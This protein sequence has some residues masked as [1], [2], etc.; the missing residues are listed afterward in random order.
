M[1]GGTLTQ[2]DSLICSGGNGFT[3]TTGTWIANDFNVALTGASANRFAINGGTIN[4][5]T[6]TWQTNYAASS[7]NWWVGSGTITNATNSTIKFVTTNNT[8]YSFLGGTKTYGN[9]WFARG[10]STATNTISSSNTFA[11]F[12]DDGSAAHS[13][14][15]T[16]G[17]TQTV[18]TFT[19]SGTAG[20]L[21][22]IDSTTTGT[23][24]LVKSGGGTISSDYLNIQHSVAT[25][26]D[27]WYAGVNSTDNQAATTA[28][29]GWIFTAPPPPPPSTG[30]EY[31]IL[32]N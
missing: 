19:V 12:K 26:S 21:I 15:F 23:H 5:G 14:L 25:P 32:F 1:V 18:T 8:D 4:M 3:L 27:T 7:G 29:S 10:A 24:A 22:S 2:Q 30:E 16:T 11:D 9:I 13:I 31:L 20:N 6:G 17:T 28:G